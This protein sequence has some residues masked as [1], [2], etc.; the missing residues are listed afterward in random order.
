MET[1]DALTFLFVFVFLLNCY[2]SAKVFMNV[3]L[4][5]TQKALQTI[6][7]WL[8]PFVGGIVVFLVHR[9]DEEP[10]RR[11]TQRNGGDGHD[12]MPGGIQ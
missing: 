2:V 5:R 4:T 7:V 12:G 3:G 11:D 9:A 10:R 1:A 8:I 6:C